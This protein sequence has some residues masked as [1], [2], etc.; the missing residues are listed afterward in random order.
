[1]SEPW[2][3]TTTLT[4]TAEMS[5]EDAMRRME[6]IHDLEAHKRFNGRATKLTSRERLQADSPHQ[7]V[8]H[9]VYEAL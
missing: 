9:S 6:Q 5:H 1:M 2:N 7:V 8:L 4:P 3:I